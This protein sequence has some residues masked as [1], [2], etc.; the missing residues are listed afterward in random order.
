MTDFAVLNPATGV[1]G[2][3]YRSATD[4]EIA[5]AIDSAA[6]AYTSWGRTTTVA[7]RAAGL[8]RVAEL[9]RERSA[10]LAAAM[11]EEMGKPLADAEGEVDFSASIFDYYADNAEAFLADEQIPMPEGEGTAVVRKAP[12]G[13]LL[14]IM[15]WNFPAYQVARFAA[16]NLATGNTVL[17]KHAPQCPRSAELLEQIFRDAGFPEGAYVNVYATIEQVETIIADP[18]VQGVSLTGSERAGAAVAEIAGRHL[19]KVVLELGGSDPFLVLGSKDLD[20]VVEAAVFARTD[21]TGQVCNAGKRFVIVDEFYDD[22]VSKFT[23]ALIAATPATPL[24]SEAAAKNLARQV[25]EAVAGGA[26]LTKAGE[27]QGAFFPSA[28]LTDVTPENPVY[29]QELFGPVAMVFRA[30]DEADAV[31]IANDT[32]YGLGSYVFSDDAEQA[33]RVADQIEAGMVYVNGVG[34]DAAELPFGGVKRSGFGRELGRFGIEEF[35]NKKL[36]RTAG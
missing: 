15:P 31:R 19:K 16:P 2:Q 30:A 9:H 11:V 23:D 10:E 14:G 21:N 27:P 32:P 26:T 7:E 17:L 25:D 8:R 35:V 28:L 20:A 36:I 12:V 18:R 3:T 24:S 1:L 13:V 4:A 33:Q 22:F 29:H 5:A 34:M 6:T